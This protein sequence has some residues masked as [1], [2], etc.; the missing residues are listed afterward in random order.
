M[1]SMPAD[2]RLTLSKSFRFGGALAGEA[3]KWLKLLGSRLTLRGNELLNTTV[4]GL[5]HGESSGGRAILCRTNAE[6]MAQVMDHL[7]LGKKVA[8]VGGTQALMSMAEAAIDLKDGRRTTHPEL[9][10]FKSWRELQDHV[11]QEESARDLKVWVQL[12]DGYGPG[13]LIAALGRLSDE[14]D[15][16]ISVSTVHKA[17]GREWTAVT[18]AQDFP[19]PSMGEERGER[20]KKGLKSKEL[21]R[22]DMMLAYVATTRAKQHLDRGG[23]GWIDRFLR[24]SEG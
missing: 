7:S 13:K 21:E 8:L 5:Y 6:A 17:K 3:N 22:A 20:E 14:A 24:E 11:T 1:D 16:Q 12:I 9:F 15:A 10:L 23:L 19:R 4:D 18:V 2:E